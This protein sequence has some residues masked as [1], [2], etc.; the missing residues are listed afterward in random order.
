MI[1][2]ESS[3]YGAF[4][5]GMHELGYVENKDFVMEWRFADKFIAGGSSDST[6]RRDCPAAR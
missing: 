1:G 6:R 4:L 2:L 3:Y 5:K